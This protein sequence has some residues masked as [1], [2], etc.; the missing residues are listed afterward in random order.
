MYTS[1]PLKEEIYFFNA[2]A[3]VI[4]ADCSQHWKH[5]ETAVPFRLD[6]ESRHTE[7]SDH[8]VVCQL[9]SLFGAAC[10]QESHN[11]V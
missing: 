7:D 3:C 6:S 11:F 9:T 1:L 5:S 8:G 10:R 2:I 4:S